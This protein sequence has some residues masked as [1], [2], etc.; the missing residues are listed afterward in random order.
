MLPRSRVK[1]RLCNYW[2]E[3]QKNIAQNSAGETVK[4]SHLRYCAVSATVCEIPQRKKKLLPGGHVEIAVTR[5]SG[6]WKMT[7]GRG[8]EIKCRGKEGR[9]DREKEKW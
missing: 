6:E 7:R 3:R 4:I 1:R 5:G 2:N 8:R 9:R